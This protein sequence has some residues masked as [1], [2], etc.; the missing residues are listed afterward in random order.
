[1]CV[2]III[3][4]DSRG[5]MPNETN[6]LTLIHTHARNSKDKLGVQT[7]WLLYNNICAVTAAVAAE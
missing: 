7:D 1:M 6:F 2:N 5:D 4:M 3:L